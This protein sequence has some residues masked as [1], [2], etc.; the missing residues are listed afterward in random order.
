M[1]WAK[2]FYARQNE[3]IGVY[4]GDV[5]DYHQE[6]VA[7]IQKAHSTAKT[8]LELGAGGGQMAVATSLTGFHVTAIELVPALAEL[9]NQLAEK[10]QQTIT[11]L[12]GDFYTVN[13]DAKFDV[14][15]YWDGFGVG[16]DNDQNRLLKRC[17]DWLKP[18][19]IMLFDVYTPWYW[20][21]THGQEMQFKT[22]CRRYEFDATNC[23]ML[24]TWWH[25]DT[26]DERVT[27]SLRCYSPADLKLL[28][29]D[30]GLSFVDVIETGGA[31]NADKQYEPHV[32]LHQAMSYTA[33]LE[34][35]G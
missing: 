13:L 7:L 22:A 27:Q 14:I 30:T 11:V 29:R 33:K 8:A 25:V 4:S 28:L 10:H 12:N 1:G 21:T 2:Q 5:Q 20:A 16:S 23:R 9:I 15:T 24:D 6:K 34:K 35:S 31:V 17:A 19:G 3:L 18:N 32:A 26:P